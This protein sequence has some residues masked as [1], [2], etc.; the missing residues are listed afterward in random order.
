MLHLHMSNHRWV[1]LGLF[2]SWG[3]YGVWV[4]LTDLVVWPKC[5]HLKTSKSDRIFCHLQTKLAWDDV[6]N[7]T[8][9]RF[10]V[11]LVVVNWIPKVF[12][13]NAKSCFNCFSSDPVDECL[14]FVSSARHPDLSPVSWPGSVKLCLNLFSH[15]NWAGPTPPLRWAGI[16]F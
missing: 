10:L 9:N 5:K 16:S 8:Y 15:L 14:V 7:L 12:D 1:E 3:L 4:A 2:F 6:W 11:F 13:Y